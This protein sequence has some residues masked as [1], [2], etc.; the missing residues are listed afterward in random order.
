MHKN[1]LPV[2]LRVSPNK[3]EDNQAAGWKVP[4]DRGASEGACRR[5]SRQM[6]VRL[7]AIPSGTRPAALERKRS[8]SLHQAENWTKNLPV[9]CGWPRA[10]NGRDRLHFFAAPS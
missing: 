2:R 3:P 4:S 1:P 8:L 5:E 6:D 9:F 10:K 7:P